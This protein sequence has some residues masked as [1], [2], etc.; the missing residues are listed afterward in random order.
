MD[1]SQ[2]DF[3][4]TLL[5]LKKKTFLEIV[6]KS[7]HSLKVNMP[8]VKFWRTYCPKDKGDELAH[9]HLDT[10][11]ICVSEARLRQ[12]TLEDVEETATHEAT[13]LV[14]PTHKWHF[15]SKHSDVKSDIWSPTGVVIRGDAPIQPKIKTKHVIDKTRCN[16]HTCNKK[17]KLQV[18]QYCKDYFCSEHITPVEPAVSLKQAEI[19]KYGVGDNSHPCYPYLNYLISEQKE[20][21]KRWSATLIELTKNKPEYKSAHIPYE[22][23][24]KLTRQ[25]IEEELTQFSDEELR[26]LAKDKSKPLPEKIMKSMLEHYEEEDPKEPKVEKSIISKLKCLLGLHRWAKQ[27]GAHNCGYGKFSQGYI[28]IDCGKRKEKIS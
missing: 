5:E 2:K 3:Q 23:S 25:P 17:T 26:E 19:N 12:M 6:E 27:G 20:N 1:K 9:I 24:I 21:D 4:D 18:C 15:H 13:H 7:A 16:S 10:G 22:E 14:D 11:R 28:C 8:E